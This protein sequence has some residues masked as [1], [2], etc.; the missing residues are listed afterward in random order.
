MPLLQNCSMI[1]YSNL[2]TKNSKSCASPPYLHPTHPKLGPG[3]GM[4]SGAIEVPNPFVAAPCWSTCIG[5]CDSL[6][7]VLELPILLS[8]KF[9]VCI[10][11]CVVATTNA[12]GL[13]FDTCIHVFMSEKL[14]KGHGSS[15]SK[16]NG[17][18]SERQGRRTSYYSEFL[19]SLFMRL[20]SCRN[21][22]QVTTFILTYKSLGGGLQEQIL[23]AHTTSSSIA[24]PFSLF[25]VFCAYLK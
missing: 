24:F 15:K 16:V 18:A 20:S 25:K 13:L 9:L 3:L 14:Q 8:S 7:P 10:Y 17:G 22:I 21:D 2:L 6:V 23:F 4:I 19:L 5:C 1:Y 12:S 11:F